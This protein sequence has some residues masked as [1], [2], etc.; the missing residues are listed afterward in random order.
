MLL[1][2][3]GW[4]EKLAKW[5]NSKDLWEYTERERESREERERKEKRLN[6]TIREGED[7]S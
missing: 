1:F 5:W 3:V 7:W 6:L 2:S 4:S